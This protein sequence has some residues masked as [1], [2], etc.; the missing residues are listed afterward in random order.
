MSIHKNI[1]KIK[2]IIINNKIN[3]HLNMNI[4]K[5]QQILSSN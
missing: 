3:V 4:N 2:Q 1:F 5:Q